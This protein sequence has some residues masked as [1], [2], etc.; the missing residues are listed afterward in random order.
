MT[1]RALYSFLVALVC[2][3][4]V[5]AQS[6]PP[7]TKIR[8]LRIGVEATVKAR[9]G[10]R[11]ETAEKPGAYV[12]TLR[13]DFGG[14]ILGRTSR[15]IRDLRFGATYYVQGKRVEDVTIGKTTE[16]FF[17]AVAWRPAYP[18]AIPTS[19]V[20]V[21]V[22][23][24]LA[25][26]LVAFLLFSRRVRTAALPPAWDQA[27]IIAGPDQGKLFMLRGSRV[28][29]GRKQDPA[30]TVCIVLDD[31]VSRQHGLLIRQ[32]NDTFYEDTNSTGGSW[33]DDLRVAPRQRVPVPPGARLRLG[34]YTVIR[35]GRAAEEDS[36]T[37][38]A[39][40]AGQFGEGVPKLP[41]GPDTAGRTEG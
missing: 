39:L 6:A 20:L 27:E 33:V 3:S 15:D 14:T 29:V 18:N 12:F 10:E 11:R 16:R 24:A 26:A 31:H 35:V 8:D 4:V 37:R 19:F 40:D 41:T 1:R 7:L 28:P 23:A 32:E 25:V 17:D 34:P 9:I 36:R 5:E 38:R 13:D 22:A 21:A 30:T 2:V